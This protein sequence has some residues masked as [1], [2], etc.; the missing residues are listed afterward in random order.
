LACKYLIFVPVYELAA[1]KQQK[2][3]LY[4]PK[5]LRNTVTCE[6]AK[7]LMTVASRVINLQGK[8]D[9]ICDVVKM[10]AATSMHSMAEVTPFLSV[11][12]IPLESNASI[13]RKENIFY[14]QIKKT[15]SAKL[16]VY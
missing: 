15:I 14:T 16:S 2:H 8:H 5:T 1:M 3:L 9:L 7:K 11:F 4:L 12:I 6:I 10:K 13:K